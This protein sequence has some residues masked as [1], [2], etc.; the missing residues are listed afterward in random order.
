MGGDVIAI[1]VVI[2]CVIIIYSGKCF[3]V[4]DAKIYP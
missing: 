2:I 4:K 3:F 1:M